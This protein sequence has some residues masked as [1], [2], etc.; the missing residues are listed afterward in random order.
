MIAILL[1][2]GLLVHPNIMKKL[3]KAVPTAGQGVEPLGAAS[4]DSA[5][6]QTLPVVVAPGQTLGEICL[7]YLG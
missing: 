6:A 2:G 5:A 3:F 7:R 1:L 4:E